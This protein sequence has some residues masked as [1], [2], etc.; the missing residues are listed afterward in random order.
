M[1]DLS[2][3]MHKKYIEK[4]IGEKLEVLYEGKEHEE[5]LEG[6]TSS[7]IKVLAKGKMAKRGHLITTLIVKSEKDYLVGNMLC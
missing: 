7:Y 5:Y 1:M 4:F 2:D 6:F 3:D